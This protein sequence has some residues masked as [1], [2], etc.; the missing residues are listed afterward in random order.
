MEFSQATASFK[1]SLLAAHKYNIA[2][3]Y[4]PGSQMYVVDHLSRAY[5]EDQGKRGDKF[6]VFALEL[7]QINPLDHIKLNGDELAIIQKATEQDPV[8]QAMKSVILLDGQR[9]VTLFPSSSETTGT[10]RKIW[11][12]TMDYSSKAVISYF[13]SQWGTESSTINTPAINVL[14]PAYVRKAPDRVYWPAMN[15]DIKEVVTQCEV[16][17]EFEAR[18][19]SLPMQT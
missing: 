2:V 6:Q 4:K 5:L 8:K 13:Q 12:Y 15:T 18:N 9:S 19:P 17:A 1:K 7:E 3:I 11:H 14:S 10:S 16:H